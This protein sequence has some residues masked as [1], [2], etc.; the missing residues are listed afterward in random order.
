LGNVTNDAQLKIASNLADLNN[1]ATART[2]LG[3]GTA[4]TKNVGTGSG[5]VAAG[6]HGHIWTE[7]SKSGAKISDL[8]VPAYPMDGHVYILRENNGTLS[9]GL[10]DTL[11]TQ[12]LAVCQAHKSSSQSLSTGVWTDVSLNILDIQNESGTIAQDATDKAMFRIYVSGYYLVEYAMRGTGG[13]EGL[14]GRVYKNLSSTVPGS[15]TVNSGGCWGQLAANFIAY[16]EAGDYIELQA[17]TALSQAILSNANMI[18]IKLD[19]IKGDKGDAGGTTVD[20]LQDGINVKANVDEINFIGATVT[21]GLDS[22]AIV[23]IPARKR[24]TTL[25]LAYTGNFTGVFLAWIPTALL[26]S[27][28]AFIPP[29]PV[30]IREITVTSALAGSSGQVDRLRC[31]SRNRDNGTNITTSDTLIFEARN[32]DAACAFND[33]NGRQWKKDVSS[34][35]I[36]LS[37]AYKYGFHYDRVSG[38]A[39]INNV[40]V[41]IELEEII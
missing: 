12:P 13:V 11:V 2:N 35:N 17:Y 32:T 6:Q 3:L 19:G 38:T 8:D 18:V 29:Y 36:T 23:T 7:V 1:V 30:K 9:W 4:A 16:Y 14:S 37:N 20:I 28:S 31:F 27:S 39:Y 26:T 10:S 24:T 34:L 41:N 22:Q 25:T 21:D 15:E 40:V 33:L 5:D